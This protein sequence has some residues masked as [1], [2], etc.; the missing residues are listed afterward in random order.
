MKL[1]KID[2]F[3]S[4]TKGKSTSI[5]KQLLKREEITSASL[6][7]GEPTIDLRVEGLLN[8]N[9]AILDML[10]EIKGM[11]GVKH[12]IWSEVIKVIGKK[13][14]MEDGISVR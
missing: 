9:G 12:V 11:N 14:E 6:C 10:E 4:T 3:I 8:C 2:F 5:G 7:I 13:T 1:R